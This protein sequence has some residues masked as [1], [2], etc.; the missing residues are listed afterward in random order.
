MSKTQ[1][2]RSDSKTQSNDSV[3]PQH[4][5]I[6]HRE[7]VESIVVAIMLAL[8]FR[9]FEAEAFVIP[10]GSMAPTLQG[11]HRDVKCPECGERYQAGASVA[12]EQ[13]QGLVTDVKCPMCGFTNRLDQS[14]AN[15]G[16]FNG[17]RILVNKFAYQFWDPQRWDVIVFKYPGNAKQNYIKRLVGLPQETLRIEHG[18]IYTLKASESE[19][20]IARKPP[21][22]MLAMLQP[23]NDTQRIPEQFITANWPHSWSSVVGSSTDDPPTNSANNWQVSEDRQRY[24]LNPAE[25]TSWLRYRHIIPSHSDWQYLRRGNCPPDASRR[26]GELIRDDYAYNDQR[27][28]RP[29][30]PKP[31]PNW[32]GDLA[33]ECD[34]TIQSDQGSLFVDLV[35][36]GD[37]FRCEIDVASGKAKLVID[38]Q[39]QFDRL[40]GE[41]VTELTAQTPLKGAGN[42]RLRMSNVD[43]QIRLWVGSTMVEFAS[44]GQLHAGTYR[45]ASIVSPQWSE[46]DPGDLSPIGIAGRNL[47]ATVSKLRVLRDIYYIAGKSTDTTRAYPLNHSDYG[48][49]YTYQMIRRVFADP[50]SWATTDLFRSRYAVEFK[51]EEGQFFPM[52]DNNPQSKDAR[53]W[54]ATEDSLF[55][56]ERVKIEHYVGRELLIGKAFY[57]YWPHGWNVANIPLPIIPNVPRMSRIR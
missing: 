10:T 25:T 50:T 21:K 45:S 35:E 44:Q 16:S 53:L 38:G 54:A 9:A 33:V 7:G 41:P 49:P 32:V 39:S 2:I 27:Y 24:Q 14:R 31:L 47:Q 12:E 28:E 42:Y 22:K 26:R 19:F 55:D 5:S 46:D 29:G 3:V 8:L 48:R 17:D 1:D 51:L 56:E 30:R 40:G 4:A 43:N 52:G 13:V 34:A 57:I 36:A 20:T 37:H 18:D 23:L 11:R 15:E 6:W